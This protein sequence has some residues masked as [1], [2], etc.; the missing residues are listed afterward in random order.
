MDQ[1][2]E[3]L[4]SVF[5]VDQ[6]VS[7]HPIIVDVNRPEEIIEVFDSIPYSKGASV[8]RMLN[9]FIGEA[10]FKEGLTSYLNKFEYGNAKSADLWDS[11]QEAYDN[12]V[13]G[14]VNIAEV[15]NTWTKQMG[16]PVVNVER[17][18]ND[19]RLTQD[20]FLVDPNANTSAAPYESPYG[21]KWEIPFTSKFKNSLEDDRTFT[22]MGV[23]GLEVSVPGDDSDWYIANFEQ[24]GYYR[25]KYEEN[26]WKALTTQLINDHE[27]IPVTDRSGLLEDSFNLAN[28]EQLSYDI[29]LDL[30]LYLDQENDYVP[31]DAAYGNFW[32]LN[33]ILRFQPAYGDWR[34]YLAKQ[35]ANLMATYADWNETL[36]HLD[37]FL[38]SDIIYLAC[39]SGNPDCLAE[40]KRQLQI[41]LNNGYVS[42]NVRSPVLRFGM[43]QDGGQENWDKMWEM[44]I[45]STLSSEKSRLLSGMARTRHVWLL[46][47]YIEYAM[48][49]SKIRSQDFFSV[50][51]YIASNPVGNPLVWDFTRANWETL[52]DRFGINSGGLGGLIPDIT[53]YYCTELKLQQM[54]EFFTKYPEAGAGTRGRQQALERVKTNI[55]WVK[56]NQDVIQQ[57]LNRNL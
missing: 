28:A 25:V 5:S 43:E 38:R 1:F 2:V 51:Y 40:A 41:Y 36:S 4:Y 7:S 50:M 53:Y 30:T 46:S 37:G 48:D 21:Y 31:W 8:L 12:N 34:T 15:M 42:P 49:E 19:L 39:G 26:N 54:E 18:G 20:W 44:Y 55:D 27:A 13:G 33:E 29:A 6:I 57:W 3:T 23:D 24:M 56:R 22:W 9:D 47:R 17:S 10:S 11:L 14:G 52:V 32:W 16:F 45:N 35:T